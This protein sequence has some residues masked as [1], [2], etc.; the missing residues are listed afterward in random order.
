MRRK[1]GLLRLCKLTKGHTQPFR[2]SGSAHG[3]G[4]LGSTVRTGGSFAST[5]RRDMS[6]PENP[7]F[8]QAAKIVKNYDFLV[9]TQAAKIVKK[10]K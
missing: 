5:Q 3:K 6:K 2:V 4:S 10:L 7:G 1:R 9:L 8:R